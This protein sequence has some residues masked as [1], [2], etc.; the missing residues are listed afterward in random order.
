MKYAKIF[1]KE[2]EQQLWESNTLG[3]HSPQV[4]LNAVFYLNGKN[5]SLRSGEEHCALKMFQVER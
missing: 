4:L 2:Q 1:T 5:I 3:L